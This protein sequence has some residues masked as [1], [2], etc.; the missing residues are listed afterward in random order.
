MVC[1]PRAAAPL[2][3]LEDEGGFESDG[4]F[5]RKQISKTGPSLPLI[6][7]T[8]SAA[9]SLRDTDYHRCHGLYWSYG[10]GFVG[11]R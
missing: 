6:R 4:V 2:E 9:L 10:L 8:V 11:P 3:A 5:E 7:D 1:F